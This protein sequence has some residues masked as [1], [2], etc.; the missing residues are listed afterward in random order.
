EFDEHIPE[1]INWEAR[2]R[3]LAEEYAELK[4]YQFTKRERNNFL[5]L[6]FAMAV[7]GYSYTPGQA[8]EKLYTEIEGDMA[9]LG[10]EYSSNRIREKLQ[11]AVTVLTKGEIKK[12]EKDGVF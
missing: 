5:R 1:I 3:E 4:N 10:L 6:I 9:S 7:K 12:L 11:E 8:K 2:Y